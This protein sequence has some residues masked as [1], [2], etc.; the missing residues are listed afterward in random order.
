M[1]DWCSMHRIKHQTTAPYTSAQNGYAE[2]LHQTLLGRVRAMHLSC[3]V[4]AFLWD[5]FCTTA[6]YLTNLTT[7]STL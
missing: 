3:N 2:H 1:H 4:P 5:E 6:A 7:L